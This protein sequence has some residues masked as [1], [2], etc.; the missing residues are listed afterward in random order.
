MEPIEV[1]LN[2]MSIIFLLSIGAIVT[3]IILGALYCFLCPIQFNQILYG[4]A[5]FLYT[6]H[7]GDY[8]SAEFTLDRFENALNLISAKEIVARHLNVSVNELTWIRAAVYLPTNEKV[9]IPL[10]NMICF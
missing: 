3:S 7:S 2:M 4:P 5:A 8:I 1:L 10:C 6:V 9:R